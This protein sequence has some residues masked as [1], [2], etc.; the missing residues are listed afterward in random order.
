MPGTDGDGAH[1]RECE[2]L[3]VMAGSCA[4]DSILDLDLVCKH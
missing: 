2:S 1:G 3:S 4:A